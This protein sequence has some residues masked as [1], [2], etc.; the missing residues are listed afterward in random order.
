MTELLIPFLLT[1]GPFGLMLTEWSAE[2]IEEAGSAR[3]V[4]IQKQRGAAPM[5]KRRNPR[6]VLYA[7]V[8][9]LDASRTPPSREIICMN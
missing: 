5:M 3:E 1:C 9:P 7:L 8:R 4:H 2:P 6:R